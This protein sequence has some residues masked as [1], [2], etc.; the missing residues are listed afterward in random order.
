MPLEGV[1]WKRD[2]SSHVRSSCLSRKIRHRQGFEGGH[3]LVK[4]T[5]AVSCNVGDCL[6]PG[7]TRCELEGRDAFIHLAQRVKVRQEIHARFG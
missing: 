7:Q 6:A 3:V 1:V 4:E 5:C 2:T